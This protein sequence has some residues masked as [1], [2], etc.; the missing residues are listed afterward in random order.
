MAIR[1]L[2]P[3]LQNL[4]SSYGPRA[5]SRQTL[6]EPDRHAGA[7]Q[8]IVRARSFA[9][10]CHRAGP[11]ACHRIRLRTLLRPRGN[12]GKVLLLLQ[13]RSL[14]KRRSGPRRDGRLA[15]APDGGNGTMSA[16]RTPAFPP[17]TRWPCC[18]RR[19]DAFRRGQERDSRKRALCE[20]NGVRLVEIAYD[21]DVDGPTL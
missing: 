4:G 9:G 19:E 15:P 16:P 14:R 12:Q 2:V 3:V 21:Q 8:G 20:K 13:P 11:I 7:D 1:L 6:D 10:G 17:M 5:P 18:S